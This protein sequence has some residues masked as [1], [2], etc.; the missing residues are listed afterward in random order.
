MFRIVEKPVFLDFPPGHHLHC[1]LCQIPNQI[2]FAG[3][4]DP[5]AISARKWQRIAGLFDLVGQAQGNLRKLHFMLLPEA[6]LPLAFVDD[7]LQAAER[8]L[9]HNSVCMI[10]LEHMAVADFHA[11]VERFPADNAEL[12]QSVTED[13]R[14]GDIEGLKVNSALTCIREGDGRCHV[15]LQAKSHPFAGE[16]TIDAR[17][18][19]YHGKIFPLWR[20][21][22]T[23]FNFMALICF[24]YLYR[25]LYQS[26]IRQVI[27]H[28][29]QLYFSTRQRLDLLA[30]LECNPKP[31]HRVFRDVLHGF[32]GE[33]LEAAPGV[34]DCITLFCNSAGSTRKSLP[35]PSTDSFG[36]SAVVIHKN[37]KLPTLQLSEFSTDDFAG[38]PLCR[39][40]FGTA[41]RLYYFNLPVF[42][43][44]DPR[45]TRMPLKVHHVYAADAA[46]GWHSI[47]P[48]GTNPA[49]SA[50]DISDSQGETA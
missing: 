13:R 29:N 43:E 35:L 46:G 49:A 44:T 33:L 17:H 36:H 47:D 12:L 25:T 3:E 23:G 22:P 11:L 9:P 15:F 5:A 8:Q 21:Q 19:L 39:L 37:H 26:N 20:S 28:A 38:L 50:P 1:L 7:A 31:E 10:G 45:T 14:S 16:E 4:T 18:D 41:S 24:D 40:R 30:V 34:R 48:R 2:R 27:D 42:H 32:Y 6:V